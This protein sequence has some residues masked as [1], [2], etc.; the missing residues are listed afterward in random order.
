MWLVAVARPGLVWRGWS[1]WDGP[2]RSG[3]S[4]WLGGSWQ[5][6]SQ[7]S[8]EAKERSGLSQWCG[9]ACRGAEGYG[10]ARRSGG[11]RCGMGRLVT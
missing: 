7:W 11:D 4:Q 6:K 2:A 10:L 8:G 3:T 9:L 5:G 1:Q